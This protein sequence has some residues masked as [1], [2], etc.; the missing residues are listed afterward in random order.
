[1]SE[2]KTIALIGQPNSGKSTIFSVMSDV[3]TSASGSTYE[4][5]Q[6]LINIF[7]EKFTVVDLPGIYSL[8]TSQTSEE[9]TLD[10]LLKGKIDLI[11][12]VVDGSLLSRSLELTVELLELGLPMIVALNMEDISSK[13][14]ISL[15]HKHL[16]SILNVP[17][18]PTQ[19]LF[20]KGVK[21]LTEHCYKRLKGKE[22][23]PSTLDYTHHFEMHL[24]KL[25]PKLDQFKNKYNA[26]PRFFAI[27][28]IENPKALPE[29]IKEAVEPLASQIRAELETEHGKDSFECVSYERHHLAMK[30]SEDISKFIDK[31]SKPFL[32][33][34]DNVL[35]HP[36]WGNFFLIVF[37]F[38]YFL[39]IFLVGDFLAKL[40]EPPLDAL[41]GTFAGLK[42]VNELAWY[43][44]N[45]AYQGLVGVL[46]IV[47]PYFLPLVFLTSLFEDTGYLSRIAFLIDGLMHK[48][49]LHG[50]S[51]VSFILGLGCSI[52]ALYATRMLEDKRDRVISALLIP[53]VPCSARI[54]VI[55]ALSAAF[56]GPYWAM[57]IFFYILLVIAGVGKLLSIFLSEPTGM[58]LEI[59]RLRKPMLKSSVK[60]T[61][62][63][64]K[65][66]I[67]E[68]TIFL[69][70][71][72]IFLG[73]VEYFG[74]AN[75]LDA[76][77]EPILH[78]ILGLPEELGS[79][80]FFGFWRKELILVMANQAL[81]V[82]TIAELPLRNP[83]IIVFIIF[84]SLYFPCFTTFVVI[85]KEFKWKIAI[86]SGIL[87]LVIATLSA[88]LFKIA[89]GA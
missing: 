7:G 47:L 56:T 29:E 41:S 69:I 79:T 4:L 37:F 57:V 70:G 44:V 55:F 9:I 36:V 67:R 25:Y 30:T 19:A 1:M 75:L 74:V 50:K 64:T 28:S 6:S 87:A 16:Q 52:P 86:Y 5:K 59:P 38:L 65:D 51:V 34:I 66:F 12:N 24:Q 8:N 61:W 80:L 14:G 31:K 76:A 68:A 40:V 39:S 48:I 10:Y 71:G 78:T 83:Q 11:V 26:K 17:V 88:F 82:P 33:R 18:V 27:K 89:L 32:E 23:A 43:S 77:F 63:K 58:V 21:D 72:G 60:S 3:K 62:L 15:D 84:V 20:G 53:F 85:V 2:T 13:Y 54:T 46:G 45:G 73:W 35:L 81:N 42:D 49:G 22:I